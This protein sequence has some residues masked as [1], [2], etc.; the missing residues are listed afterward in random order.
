ML[1]NSIFAKN[2]DI[3]TYSLGGM[4]IASSLRYGIFIS[5]FGSRM[6]R[7][8]FIAFVLP[9][10]FFANILPFSFSFNL[11]YHLNVLLVGSSIFAIGILWSVL[12]D[13]AGYPYL[14][15]TF[16]ILQAFLS[17]WTENKQEKM[18]DIFGSR[19]KEDSVRTRL[20]KFE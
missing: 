2:S 14:K 9:V 18:E 6:I 8:L 17:A 11:E 13:R 10:I 4:F 3:I 7:S 15:S 20:L 5:V 16:S 12:A 1:A 19:S